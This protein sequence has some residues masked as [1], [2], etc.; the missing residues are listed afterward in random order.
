MRI[1]ELTGLRGCCGMSLVHRYPCDFGGRKIVHRG[2]SVSNSSDLDSGGCYGIAFCAR[3]TV[4]AG[5]P[6]GD[7][8]GGSALPLGLP[9]GIEVRDRRSRDFGGPWIARALIQTAGSGYVDGRDDGSS[10]YSPHERRNC[11]VTAAADFWR[12]GLW[13][14]L[15]APACLPA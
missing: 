12:V 1:F 13:A 7:C 6:A 9:R 8:L 2:Q 5:R 15:V 4:K 11:P 3:G 14:L 10:T